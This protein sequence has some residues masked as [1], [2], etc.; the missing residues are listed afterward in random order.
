MLFFAF[1]LACARIAHADTVS[2]TLDVRGWV[3]DYQ[4]PTF[5]ER[6]APYALK[7]T[8]RLEAILANNSFPGPAI[9]A[10]EG[11]IIEVKVVN[12]LIDLQIAL[13]F[14]GV[15]AE[16]STHPIAQQG[17]EFTYKVHA[18][19]AG[20]FWWHSNAVEHAARGLKGPIVV[21]KR[22]D[23]WSGKYKS[24]MVVA[25]SDA[26]QDPGVCFDAEGS[27]SPAC[28]EI[29]KAHINGQ[30]GDGSKEWPLPQL[31]VVKGNCYRLRFIGMMSQPAPY[32]MV[33]IK[34]H[35]FQIINGSSSTKVSEIKVPAGEHVDTLVCANQKGSLFHPY[36]SF[37]L[38]YKYI[39]Q[40][41]SKTFDASLQYAD[42]ADAQEIVTPTHSSGGTDAK[43]QESTQESSVDG[44][45]SPAFDRSQCDVDYTWDL[46]DAVVDYLRPTLD[47]GGKAARKNP[48]DIPL[49]KRKAALLVN[50]SYP[51]P[52]LEAIEGQLICITVLNNFKSDPVS[53]HWHGQ[54]VKGYPAFD[55]VY[56]VTQGAINPG[57]SFTYRFRGNVG[58][59]WYHAHMQALQVDRGLKG[60]IV[61][62]AKSDPHKKMYDEERIVTISDE[63]ANP[64]VC[65]RVEG[66]QPGNPVCAEIDKATWNGQWGDGS[67][68]YPWPFITVE[69]GK[70]YRLRFIG[71]MGQAQNFQVTM[72]G[73]NMTII[74]VDGVDTVPTVV[75]QFNL[76]AGER[77]DVVVC[78][79][80]TP[81]NYLI[82]AVYDLATFLETAPAPHMPKVDSSKF[83]S[84]LNYKGHTEQPGKAT[85]KLLGGYHAPSGTGGG[86][87]P[88]A[89]VGPVWDTNIASAWNIV[90]NLNTEEL[91][92][93]ADVT[94]TF[95][96]GVAHPSFKPGVTSYAHSDKLYMFPNITSWRKPDTPLLHTKG[97]C[98]AENV[99]FLNVP[100]SAQWVEVVINNLSPTAHVLHMH[101]MNFKV[102][103]A[104]AFSESWCAPSRFDCFFLPIGVAKVVDCPG[105]RLGDPDKDGPGSE[106]WGCPYDA[107]KDVK[108]QNLKDPMEKDMVTI[109]RRSW[110]V[111]RFK[112]ENPGTWIFHC[113]MEQ[114]IPTGQVMAFNLLPS[115]Q[116]PIPADVPTE[117]PCSV[118]SGSNAPSRHGWNPDTFV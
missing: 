101:G 51:G 113:H 92:E 73:H 104:A 48:D 83:W 56:G 96:I 102:I 52:A 11:D 57:T 111:I 15:Q 20:T 66:A 29:E 65:L 7:K 78:A 118:W 30:W 58:T 21:R 50:N 103:N 95:D 17:G 59:H 3:V 76:H 9:E 63:W 115:K 114:H 85:K 36:P 82:E 38:T 88:K 94:Y 108:T 79:D 35:E 86:L 45:E 31:E 55:G 12:S 40:H 97:K 19:T 28:D 109:F 5:G 84:F 81:G 18:V 49:D 16:K 90:K 72:A 93:K 4:R 80:Q 112:V 75:S 37:P 13:E 8:D 61:I 105:A 43:H 32:F 46:R 14:E 1:V 44:Q 99:P 34:D 41:M 25:L 110:V 116:P 68:E 60:P 33:N 106:Y 100:E 87:H 89:T 117:G 42:S 39:G 107:E 2:Y 27:L 26:R 6:I 77:F 24:E 53:I 70:C 67:E 64:G 47:L 23:P 91:P 74:A 98:G 10:Y 62:H 71:M 69:Q 22:N 54:H